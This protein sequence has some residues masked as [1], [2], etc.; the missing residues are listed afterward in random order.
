MTQDQLFFSELFKDI[1]DVDLSLQDNVVIPCR[2]FQYFDHIGCAFNLHYF[3][4]FWIHI[5]QSDFEQETCSILLAFFLGQKSQ[6]PKVIDL[7]VP[8]HAK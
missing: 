8:R 1:Q 6:D 3:I 4:Q 7:N 5:W 2:F